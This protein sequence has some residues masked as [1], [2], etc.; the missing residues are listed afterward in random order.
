MNTLSNI[1]LVIGCQRSGTSLLAS[2]LG[3]HSEINMLYESTT[4][5]SLFTI[6]KKYS[7]N[8]LLAW[9]QIRW[10]K[11]ASRIGHLMNRLINA[12]FGRRRRHHRVRLFPTSKLSLKDYLD[13]NGRIIVITRNKVDV[14]K[15]IVRRTQMSAYQAERE[16]DRSMKLISKLHHVALLIQFNDLVSRPEAIMKG[17]CRYLGL[18]YESRMLEGPRFNYVYP[19]AVFESR[20]TPSIALV[21]LGDQPATS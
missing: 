14:I 19:R 8:K 10:D 15:S 20:T 21:A 12:D 11:R 5:D 7:G 6:G 17:V 18:E 4:T 3:R 9:R 13:V 2:M 16:Y 1:L